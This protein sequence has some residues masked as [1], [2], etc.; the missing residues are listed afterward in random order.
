M[1]YVLKEIDVVRKESVYFHELSS[2]D[3]IEG[4][5]TTV[6]KALDVRGVVILRGKEMEQVERNLYKKVLTVIEYRPVKVK[7]TNAEEK[8]AVSKR[9]KDTLDRTS[10]RLNFSHVS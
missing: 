8:L 10:T 6:G 1:L 5:I 4:T 7:Y 9:F 2:E 3:V